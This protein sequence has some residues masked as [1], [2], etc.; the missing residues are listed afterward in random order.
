M[1]RLSNFAS[2][3]VRHVAPSV[4]LAVLARRKDEL[5]LTEGLQLETAAINVERAGLKMAEVVTKC[6]DDKT[7]IP[8]AARLSKM[9]QL[10]KAN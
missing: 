4:D 5:V 10:D 8:R 7:I 9:G 1:L 2:F 6:P 3:L